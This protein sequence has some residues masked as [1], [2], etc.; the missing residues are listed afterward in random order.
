[1]KE[2]EMAGRLL[3]VVCVVALVLCKSASAVQLFLT[4]T[5]WVNGSNNYAVTPPQPYL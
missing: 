1:M 3:V 4:D 5:A 2:M